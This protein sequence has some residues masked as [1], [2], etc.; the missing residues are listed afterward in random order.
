[1]YYEG[2]HK[3]TY[4]GFVGT[5]GSI[6]IWAY[7]HETT[8]TGLFTLHDRYHTDDHDN[9]GLY[10]MKSGRI[11]AYYQKHGGE[12]FIRYRVSTNPEDISQW[13]NGQTISTNAGATYTHIFLLP[14]E[15]STVF[16]FTRALEWHPNMLMSNDDGLTWSEPLVL[17]GGGGAR[18]YIKYVSDGSSKIHFAFTDGHPR[19]EPTNSIY[20]AY[21][22]SGEF[23]KA[24]GTKLDDMTGLPIEPKTEG[25][26]IYDGSTNGRAWIW[27]IA[28]DSS[29]YPV[30]VHSVCPQETDH[31]YYYARWDGEKWTDR[32]IATAGKW[33]PCCRATEPEPHY[34]GG[35]VLDH[36]NPSIV[37]LSR[38]TNDIFEIEKWV[39]SDGGDTWESEM[40]TSGSAKNNVRPFAAWLHPPTPGS[41]PG[42]NMLFWMHGD[43]EHYTSFSTGI[44]YWIEPVPGCPDSMYSEYN[45]DRT[46]DDSSLC[47]T[48]GT[49]NRFSE[50]TAAGTISITGQKVVLSLSDSDIRCITVSDHT[51]KSVSVRMKNN[52]PGIVSF[53]T[54]ELRQGIYLVR[55]ISERK[56][57]VLKFSV[58]R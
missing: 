31:R 20:Y 55:A 57:F 36:S 9:P 38:P 37:Y 27:D 13:E 6:R 10:I 12:Q 2:I 54:Q 42:R 58:I 46:V 21:Y 17:I 24:D 28:V 47:R 39:T 32:E 26:L 48:L 34:S 14:K 8:D 50:N 52:V 35:I 43:Y 53:S 29:G 4:C 16:L 15:D 44:K 22:E 18:P 11:I 33:F 40:I 30:L 49:G 5:E 1:V 41:K 23:F 25:E 51:G 45:P 19:N 7:D 3:K 56:V